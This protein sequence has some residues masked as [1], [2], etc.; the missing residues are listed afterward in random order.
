MTDARY[1]PPA[2]A[3][4]PHTTRGAAIAWAPAPKNLAGPADTR[5]MRSFPRI[6]PTTRDEDAKPPH[7]PHYPVIKGQNLLGF[8]WDIDTLYSMPRGRIFPVGSSG[9]T[10][11]TGTSLGAGPGLG[12]LCRSAQQRHPPARQCTDLG[13]ARLNGDGGSPGP[14]LFTAVAARRS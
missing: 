1:L 11:F 8:G 3:C 6:A 12:Y 5:S 2:K 9:L 10:G 14:C 4:G 7:T 13:P